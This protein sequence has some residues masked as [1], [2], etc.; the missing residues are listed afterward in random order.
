MFTKDQ[1]V[2]QFKMIDTEDKGSLSLDK[3]VI[4]CQSMGM[5]TTGHKLKDHFDQKGLQ[6]PGEVTP[7]EFVQWFKAT[8][9]GMYKDE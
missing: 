5:N 3:V 4:V 6:T 8:Q 1:L 2:K 7:E 9:P